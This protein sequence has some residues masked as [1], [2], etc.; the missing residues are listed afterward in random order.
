M[1]TLDA[2]SKSEERLVIST[3]AARNITVP[4]KTK[5][6]VG[7]HC[8]VMSGY[9]QI[10]GPSPSGTINDVPINTDSSWDTREWQVHLIIG[11]VWRDC[12]PVGVNR[13]DTTPSPTGLTELVSIRF[14]V[15]HSSASIFMIG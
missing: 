12:F 11:P 2:E 9:G 14:P 15:L 8:V 1:T 4:V 7:M 10:G 3:E 6:A 5:V 13:C